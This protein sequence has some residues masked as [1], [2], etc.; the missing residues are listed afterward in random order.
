MDTLQTYLANRFDLSR[1]MYPLPTP[2]EDALY[3]DVWREYIAE[4]QEQEVFTVLQK[5]LVQLHFP[6][7]SGISQTKAYRAVTRQGK[8]P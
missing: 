2:L 7:Q 8:S 1:I 4:A 5:K 6:I 3:V